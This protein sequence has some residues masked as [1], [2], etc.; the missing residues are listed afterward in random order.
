MHQHKYYKHTQPRLLQQ[1][2]FKR[3]IEI[4]IEKEGCRK[5]KISI[6]FASDNTL[7]KLNKEFL[8]RNYFTDVIA[9]SNSFKKNISGEV[10][11]SIDRVKE[12]SMKYS[13]GEFDMELKRVVIHGILHLIGYNDKTGREKEIMTSR[14]ELYL[15]L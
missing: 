12:N 1:E 4:I 9:F 3:L 10:Y 11:I 13:E 7:Q 8:K 6:I 5:G 15:H 14:E 2:S